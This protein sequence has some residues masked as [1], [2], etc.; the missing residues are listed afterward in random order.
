MEFFITL[1]EETLHFFGVFQAPALR[2]FG[3]EIEKGEIALLSGDK[4]WLYCAGVAR[5][6][7]EIIGGITWLDFEEEFVPIEGLDQ[8]VGHTFHSAVIERNNNYCID[9]SLNQYLILISYL[10]NLHLS[11]IF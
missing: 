2:H 6:G 8:I 11:F 1:S 4:Y 3:D 10:I 7:N 5:F 9:C